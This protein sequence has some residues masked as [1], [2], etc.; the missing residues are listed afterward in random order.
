MGRL[1]EFAG[2]HPFLVL[3]LIGTWIAVLV[4][5]IRQKSLGVTHV[6]APDA[7]RLINRGAV[8]IDVRSPDQF[9]TGHII[10]ARNVSLA[11]IEAD[12]DKLKKHK[13]KVLLTVCDNGS[14]S[15]RAAGLLRKAG[16]ERVFSIKGG[17]AGWRAENLPVVK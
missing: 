4:Y 10:N 17:L 13:K 6:P 1:A 7:V 8:V 3:G 15:G 16:Y 5:E 9:G 14:G 12:P 2:N 11:D